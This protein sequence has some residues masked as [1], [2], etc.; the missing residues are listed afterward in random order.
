MDHVWR[1]KSLPSAGVGFVALL[2]ISG[3]LGP[4]TLYQTRT[5]YNDAVQVTGNEELLLNLVRLRYGEGVTFLPITALTA[6]FEMDAGLQGTG[7]VDRGFPHNLGVGNLGY[8]D[9]PTLSFDPRR[10]AEV[11]KALLARIDLDTFNLLDAAGWDLGRL[12]RILVEDI[13]GVGNAI[14]ASGPIP[15]QAPEFA[16][17]RYLTSLVESLHEQ[18]L[19]DLGIETRQVDI[20]TSV[21]FAAVDAQSLVSIQKS[22]YGIRS[23]GEKKGYVLT[24]T[25]TVKGIRLLPEAANSHEMHEISRLTNIMPGQTFYEIDVVLGNQ[26]RPFSRGEPRTNLT[27][28]TRSLLEA[29]YFLSHGI[30][31]PPEHARLV[32]ITRNPDGTPFDWSAVTADLLRVCVAKHR[33]KHAAVAVHYRSHWYFI[34][35]TDIRSKT[36]LSLFRELTRLQKVGAAEGPP[37]LTLPVGK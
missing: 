12:F 34:A 6:Q 27:I 22:G 8:S 14:S 3:C 36:T 26:L 32:T 28:G 18:R 21:P 13:N 10:S 15:E 2:F 30:C 24:Q 16:E 19:L 35:D 31:V 17:F 20:P 5:R 1:G 25:K 11:T 9:R 33:P 23:L 29:M 7:G 37:L 4:Q